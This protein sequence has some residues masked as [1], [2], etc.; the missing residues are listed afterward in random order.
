MLKE[1][2]E[3]TI[4]QLDRQIGNGE[5]LE[6]TGDADWGFWAIV[7][8][9]SPQRSFL[10]HQNSDGIRWAWSGTSHEVEEQFQAINEEFGQVEEEEN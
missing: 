3:R 9:V 5:A 2:K 1:C 10:F 7:R 6:Q 4:N 8:S